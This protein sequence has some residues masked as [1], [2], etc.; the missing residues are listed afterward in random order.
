MLS[1]NVT[2]R[3][4]HAK[5]RPPSAALRWLNCPASVNVVPLYPNDDS[6]AS[7]KGDKVH[8]ALEDGIVFGLVPDTD[9]PDADMNVRDVMEWVARKKAEYGEEIQVYAE[10]VYD[11]PEIASYGTCDLTLVTPTILHIAD[12]KNGY[13]MTDAYEQM[14]TYLLGAIAKFGE[15]VSYAITVIQPNYNH[16]DGPYRTTP[17]SPDEVESFKRRVYLAMNA[18]YYKSGSW[19]KKSYCPHRGGCRTFLDWAKTE[20]EDA[21]FPH[22]VNAITDDQLATAL[23]HSDTLHGIR[24]EYRKEAMRRMAQHGRNIRGYK[25]VKSRINREFAGDAGREACYLALRDIGY[26]TDDLVE[27][28]PFKVGEISIYETSVLAVAGVERMVKQKYKKFGAGK[29]KIIWDEYF[30]PHIR[31]YSGSLTLERE[32]DGRPAHTRGSEFG[33]LNPAPTLTSLKITHVI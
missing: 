19:C 5:E 6:E 26:G 17:I 20:G 33:T 18:V 9:D 4:E 15:R 23:D 16:R 8:L 1:A 28:K 13:V 31:E 11:I 10:Q 29:W 7:R 32:T 25:L 21:Y 24:D 12:Y 3:P 27:R 2:P 30:R 22:E 14:M